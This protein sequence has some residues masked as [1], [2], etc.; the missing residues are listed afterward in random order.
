MGIPVES[1]DG[2]IR[3]VTIFIP[4]FEKVTSGLKGKHNFL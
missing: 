3:K 2:L 1:N 4:T